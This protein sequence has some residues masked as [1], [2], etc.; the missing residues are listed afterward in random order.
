[1]NQPGGSNENL[2]DEVR[3]YTG[4]RASPIL[5]T[6]RIGK[7]LQKH[8]TAFF[9]CRRDGCVSP[10]LSQ[11]HHLYIRKWISWSQL[12]RSWSEIQIS[13]LWFGY[14]AL[15]TLT[16][17]PSKTTHKEGLFQ[18]NIWTLLHITMGNQYR[19]FRWHG[20]LFCGPVEYTYL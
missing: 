13:L 3:G 19:A 9:R 17:C 4:I 20:C 12:K 18:S 2:N 5:W 14:P 11:F 1:M 6:K 16:E 7:H 15:W 10:C 8:P